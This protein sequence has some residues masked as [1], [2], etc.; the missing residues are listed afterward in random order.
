MKKKKLKAFSLVE[1]LVT[2]VVFGILLAMLSQVLLLNL[3]VSRKIQ[4]RTRVREELAELVGLLQRD[5]RNADIIYI[6]AGECDD[7]NDFDMN[8][9]ND[10][11]CRMFV[12]DDILWVDG[13][14][15]SCPANHLCKLQWSNQNNVLY[16]SSDILSVDSV[17]FQAQEFL[18]VENTSATLIVTLNVA[19]SNPNWEVNN[20]VRQ[21]TVST[22]NF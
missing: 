16:Q 14:H 8:S 15:G 2:L 6:G 10:R 3:Q 21:I 1:T 17:S 7:T 22:R 4:A 11:G 19:A 9:Q 5:V 12:T 20:Q 18:S 13:G